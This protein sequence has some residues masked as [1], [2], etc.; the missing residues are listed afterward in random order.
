[1][2]HQPHTGACVLGTY[3]LARRRD[4]L[5][6]HFDRASSAADLDCWLWHRPAVG[7]IDAAGDPLVLDRLHEIIARETP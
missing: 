4:Q 7:E 6:A 3:V 1:V 2:L 5:Q